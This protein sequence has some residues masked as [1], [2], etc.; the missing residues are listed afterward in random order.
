VEASAYR[1]ACAKLIGWNYVPTPV[2][3]GVFFEAG[4][5]AEWHADRFPLSTVL[6]LFGHESFPSEGVG[7]IVCQVLPQLFA[8]IALPETRNALLVATLFRI[9]S[10]RDWNSVI[11]G[12]NRSLPLVFG[13]NVVHC[14]EAQAVIA[15]WLQQHH[16]LP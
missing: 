15:A 11:E 10:R 8:E 14:M 6:A 5:V 1:Q 13:L 4:R 2:D 16:P 12:I 3:G 9:A 7:R